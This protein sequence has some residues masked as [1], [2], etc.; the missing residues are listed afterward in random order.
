[1]NRPDDRSPQDEEAR[2]LE[3][4]ACYFARRLDDRSDRLRD[5]LEAWLSADPR[6]AVAYARASDAWDKAAGLR[7]LPPPPDHDPHRIRDGEPPGGQGR[8]QQ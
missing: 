5:E 7:S 1:M 8:E 3:Q 4:A 6:N 2:R